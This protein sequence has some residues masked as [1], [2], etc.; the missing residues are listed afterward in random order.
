MLFAC[1]SAYCHHSY[2]HFSFSFYVKKIPSVMVLG[3]YQGVVLHEY[4]FDFKQRPGDGGK[5]AFWVS[6]FV[7]AD[8]GFPFPFFSIFSSFSFLASL[9]R[10]VMS[11]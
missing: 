6:H 7:Y 5:D 10:F 8:F 4:V 1:F 9:S 3:L 11:C 2:Y